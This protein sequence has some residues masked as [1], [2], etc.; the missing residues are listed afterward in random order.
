MTMRISAAIACALSI[1]LCGGRSAVVVPQGGICA[2][3][4]VADLREATQNDWI[5]TLSD[6]KVLLSD[7]GQGD[8]GIVPSAGDEIG[9][10]ELRL[11]TGLGSGILGVSTEWIGRSALFT[12]RN[13]EGTYRVANSPLSPNGRGFFV[14]TTDDTETIPLIEEAAGIVRLAD[15]SARYQ[16]FVGLVESQSQPLF[17]KRFA[18]GQIAWLG[19]TESNSGI[20]RR[21]QLLQWRD[22]ADVDSELRLFVD[23]MMMI[24]GQ[25]S[26]QWN[27][28][29]LAFLRNVRDGSEFTENQ[30]HVAKHRLKES[31]RT[32]QAHDSR[33][34][35]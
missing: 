8:Q 30:K 14:F 24:H 34:Q 19:L 22:D 11:N 20:Q 32:K 2:V 25:P 26:Y 16:R 27:E 5:V 10:L 21:S 15:D 18:I 28:D 33:E 35:Q 17:L 3:G 1:F 31:G 29:R 13:I 7:P 6:V 12:V 23:Y 9:S 4:R